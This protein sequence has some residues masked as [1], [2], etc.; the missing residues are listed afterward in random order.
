MPA[1]ADCK[2]LAA[3]VTLTLSAAAWWAAGTRAHARRACGR[4]LLAHASVTHHVQD[5]D[6]C[7]LAGRSTRSGML[8]NLLRYSRYA[9]VSGGWQCISPRRYIKRAGEHRRRVHPR[10]R[11]DRHHPPGVQHIQG[12]TNRHAYCTSD[13]AWARVAGAAAAGDGSRPIGVRR[14]RRPRRRSLRRPRFRQRLRTRRWEMGGRGSL[15]F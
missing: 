4:S 6:A 12:L 5:A 9:W 15:C 3:A 7:A 11:H 14:R 2:S 13:V 8:E 10:L 1:N